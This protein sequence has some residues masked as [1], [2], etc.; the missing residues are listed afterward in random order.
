MVLPTAPEHGTSLL[1]IEG[2]LTAIAFGVAFCWPQL[3]SSWYARL[4]RALG[5][6]ARRKSLSVAVIGLAAILL[7]LAILPVSPIPQPFSHDDFSF[8]LAADTF[9]SGRL[10]NPSPAMW[11]HFESFH[12]S[13]KPTYMSMYFP[14]QGLV[15]AAGKVFAGRATFHDGADEIVPGI[16]VHH[17]GGHSRG[18]QCVRV[19]TRRGPVVLASDTSHLYAHFEEGRVFPTTY[20][21]AEV[22][23]GYEALN[24]LAH[25]RRHIVPGHDPKVLERYPA[26]R[27]G[28][29]NWVVRLDADPKQS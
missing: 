6:L 24:K 20:N 10:T 18:L 29:E 26:A 28:L 15:L 1:L 9:A 14:A 27:P 23:E 2:S 4:E 3:G 11:M 25:S 21:I 17:I 19:E 22:L 13:V 12:I 8:L 5:R 16:T 7:R